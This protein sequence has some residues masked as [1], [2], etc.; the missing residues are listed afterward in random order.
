VGNDVRIERVEVT[1]EAA[2][3]LLT[4]YYRD[5]DSRFPGGF[6]VGRSTAAPLDELSP[7]V[8]TFLVA[9]LHERSVGCGGIRRLTDEVAEIKRMYV[10]PTA[11]GRGVARN[12]LAAL[13]AE[14]RVLG[15]R[16][17]RLDT[18][19]SLAE[20]IGLYRGCGYTEIPAYNDNLY[21]GHWFEKDLRGSELVAGADP[22]GPVAES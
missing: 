6:D 13:E 21:A 3:A 10:D 17:A 14:A 18:H 11:R 8:G 5:L 4:S 15:C 7:P 1:G 19:A 22:D 9:F 12:L 2:Q 16:L 20:A